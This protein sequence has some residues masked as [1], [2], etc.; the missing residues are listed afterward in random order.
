LVILVTVGLHTDGFSRLV[1]EMDRMAGQVEEEVV[2]QIG[3]TP[4]QPRAAR[5]FTFTSQQEVETLCDQARIVVSHAGAGS[6]LMALHRRKP[7]IVMPRLQKYGEHANDHQLEL[8]EALSE[9]GMLLVAHETE[10]LAACLRVAASF[11][12]PARNHSRLVEA[13][14]RAVSGAVDEREGR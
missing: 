1:R 6:I 13:V 4:Y 7:L 9:A 2:M 12:P 8:A 14:R 3:A 5:W 11:S 10:E